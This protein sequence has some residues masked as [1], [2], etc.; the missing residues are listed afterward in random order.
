MDLLVKIADKVLEVYLVKKPSDKSSIELEKKL[1]QL[2]K[3]ME[4][5]YKQVI[6]IQA[7]IQEKVGVCTNCNSKTPEVKLKSNDQN[8]CQMCW[9]HEKFG[10]RAVKCVSPCNY[11]RQQVTRK[12]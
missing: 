11:K 4:N 10:Y 3:K 9:Y 8:L 2:L 7:T 1:D 6:D 5:L 12:L